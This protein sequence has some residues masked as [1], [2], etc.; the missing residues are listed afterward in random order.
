[1]TCFLKH[2]IIF[3]LIQIF[4]N[5]LSSTQCFCGNWGQ[6]PSPE[7]SRSK[8]ECNYKCTGDQSQICG[9]DWRNSVY[10]TGLTGNLLA[11]ADLYTK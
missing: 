5:S 2:K 1:M 3:N 9:G 4:I 6:R 7:D 11:N 8:S 10:E